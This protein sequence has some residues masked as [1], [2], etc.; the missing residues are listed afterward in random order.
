MAKPF[1]HAR[2]SAKKWGGV[3]EDYV[4]IHDWFDQTKSHFPDVRHRALL[5]SSFGIYLAEQVFGHNIINS[6]GKAVSVRDVGEQH[7]LED[8]GAIP[9]V[10]DYLSR[11]TLQPWMGGPSRKTRAMEQ[12]QSLRDSLEQRLAPMR[13]AMDAVRTKMKDEGKAILHDALKS[14]FDAHPELEAVKWTQYTPYFN[15]GDAC[16]FSVN[17]PRFRTT[18]APEDVGYYEDGFWDMPWGE[19]NPEWNGPSE[20]IASAVKALGEMLTDSAM[21]EVLLGVFG[22]HAEIT[23]TRDGIEVD[24]YAHD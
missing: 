8:L 14:L 16:E 17:E 10:Q 21:G 19:Y 4:A 15:D 6:A 7:V 1:V 5:H 20:S 22:D 9:T 23:A 24:S 11:M 2:S 12:L 18:G 13:E 3:P